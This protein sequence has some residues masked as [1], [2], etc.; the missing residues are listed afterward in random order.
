MNHVGYLFAQLVGKVKTNVCK[1]LATLRTVVWTNNWF[2]PALSWECC[3]E[4][5]EKSI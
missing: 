4:F 1:L 5:F 3:W 2:R